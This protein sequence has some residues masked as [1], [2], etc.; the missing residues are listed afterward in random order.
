MQIDLEIQ[1]EKIKKNIINEKL[2]AKNK[3]WEEKRFNYVDT[4]IFY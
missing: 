2:S 1:E 3:K 4:I